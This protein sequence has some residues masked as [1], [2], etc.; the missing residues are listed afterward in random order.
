MVDK[1]WWEAADGHNGIFDSL[2]NKWEK[3]CIHSGQYI[4][5]WIFIEKVNYNY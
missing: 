4:D 5:I 3:L 1:F 2:S